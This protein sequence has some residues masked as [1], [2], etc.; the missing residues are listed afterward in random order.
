MALAKW[1][2]PEVTDSAA[3]EI[4]KGKRIIR[5]NISAEP[6]SVAELCC[7]LLEQLALKDS[8]L[9][10]AVHHVAE[11]EAVI[12]LLP[13][14]VKAADPAPAPPQVFASG[15]TAASLPFPL[16]WMLRVYGYSIMPQSEAPPP[17]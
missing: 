2:I 3:F 4:E 6:N 5:S 8:I 15:Q 17:D 11:L 14:Q 7:S 1:F 9:R 16:R 10:K 13:T 12:A